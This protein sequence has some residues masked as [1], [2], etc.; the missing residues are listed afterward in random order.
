MKKKIQR[1]VGILIIVGLT[2]I[3]AHIAKAHCIYNTKLDSSVYGNMSVVNKGM[4]E[5]RFTTTEKTLDAV[6]IKCRTIGDVENVLIK[7]SILN[8]ENGSVLYEGKLK[9]E[10]FKNS[11]FAEFEFP[12]IENTSGKEYAIQLSSVG[13]TD[14]NQITFCYVTEKERNTNLYFDGEPTEGTMVAKIITNRFDIETFCVLLVFVLYIG[15]FVKF[16][17]RLFK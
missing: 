4:I 17:Y 11:K 15:L 6:R 7:Y 13:E 10:T 14:E 9:G 5:Q 2:F 8:I 16:L 12:T 1:I 3:Y